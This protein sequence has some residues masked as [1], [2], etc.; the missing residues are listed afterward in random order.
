LNPSDASDAAKVS[1]HKFY[2]NIEVY[3][4]SVLK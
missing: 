3:F 2:T 1:S 4:N